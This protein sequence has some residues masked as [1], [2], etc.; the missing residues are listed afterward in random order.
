MNADA[1][2]RSA[3]YRELAM[4]FT[5]QGAIKSVFGISGADYV[6]A[7]DPSAGRRACSLW[8]RSHTQENESSLFEELTRFYEF[9]G[10]SRGQ[11]T[12]TPDHISVELEFM[13][14]LTHLESKA[15][16]RPEDL[17][18]IRRAERDYLHRH[19][20]RVIRGINREFKSANR[21]CTELVGTAREFIDEELERV[22]T[23]A[24]A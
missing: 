10:L 15:D 16:G 14:Y 3:I 19:L 23:V 17:A 9:F 8:E 13:H 21:G 22:G 11:G 20:S 7:F 1:L 2:Q 12:E 18:S 5:Y 4:A 24:G 6:E